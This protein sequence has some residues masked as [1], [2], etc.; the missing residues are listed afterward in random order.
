MGAS[1]VSLC[2]GQEAFIRVDF[3][4]NGSAQSNAFWVA[5]L[6]EVLQ[7]NDLAARL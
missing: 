6:K 5:T 3:K 2:H 4:E 7:A 1:T